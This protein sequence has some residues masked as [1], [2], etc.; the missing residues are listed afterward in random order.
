MCCSFQLAYE[1][2]ARAVE[3]EHLNCGS[4]QSSSGMTAVSWSDSSLSLGALVQ[5]ESL[6]SSEGSRMAFQLYTK[7]F[8]TNKH[9]YVYE[10]VHVFIQFPKGS[11]GPQSNRSHLFIC[12]LWN[13]MFPLHL[14]CP[15][16]KISASL[17]WRHVLELQTDLDSNPDSTI[18]YA[19][20][21]PSLE[22]V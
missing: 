19:C 11:V 17:H 2:Q 18:C 5:R 22:N 13:V 15:E 7:H 10:K 12:C 16:D 9:I 14:Q 21:L 6:M 1:R 3:K 4:V 20:D 8:S